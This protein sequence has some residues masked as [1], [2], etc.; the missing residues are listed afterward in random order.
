MY[1]NTVFKKVEMPF[2]ILR[3][4]HSD[5]RSAQSESDYR[6]HISPSKDSNDDGLPVIAPLRTKAQE[7]K[8]EI[9]NEDWKRRR[10]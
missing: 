1:H 6:I 3:L 5:I 8:R 10:I 9:Q 2:M 7:L 4:P